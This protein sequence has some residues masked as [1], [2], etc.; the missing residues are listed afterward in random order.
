MPPG[1]MAR[2]GRVIEHG[3]PDGFAVNGAIV[4][5]PVS[6]FAPG[7]VV[8]V[9]DAVYDVAVSDFPLEAHGLGEAN[10]H[11]ALFGIAKGYGLVRRS[12]GDFKIE[13]ALAGRCGGEDLEHSL[14]G[15]DQGAI[16]RNPIVLFSNDARMFPG[17]DRG[18]TLMHD[19]AE[20]FCFGPEIV[21]V[22]RAVSE[23]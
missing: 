12:E 21:S 4:I 22:D 14:V 8:A 9:S 18:K 13:T 6:A 17:R 3:D 1:R 23:P 15:A 20:A 11:G 7:T 10:R 16:G 2:I 19:P 5:T